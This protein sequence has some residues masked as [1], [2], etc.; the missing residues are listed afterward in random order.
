MGTCLSK[1]TPSSPLKQPTPPPQPQP[2]PNHVVVHPVKSC[3]NDTVDKVEDKEQKQK[4]MMLEEADP[5]VEAPRKVEEGEERVVKKKEVFVIKHRKSHDRER[6]A[7]VEESG[8]HDKMDDMGKARTT[9]DEVEDEVDAILI[10]CGRLSRSNSSGAGKTISSSGRKYSGSK[11]SFDFDQEGGDLAAAGD[12]DDVT[13]EKRQHRQRNRQPQSPQGRRRTRTPSRER[14]QNQRSGSRER[15]NGRRVSRSPGRRSEGATTTAT[16]IMTSNNASDSHNVASGSVKRPA[17]MVSVPPTVSSLA[18]DK[19]NE[20]QAAAAV[21]SSNTIKRIS[22]KR[23]VEAAG[24]RSSASPRSQSP[25][26]PIANGS[27]NQQPSLSRSSSRKA[28]HSPYRRNPLTDIDTNVLPPPTANKPT[29]TNNTLTKA[30]DV[31]TQKASYETAN[32]A[33]T[34]STNVAKEQP[35]EEFNAVLTTTVVPESLNPHSSSRS[36]SARQSRDLDFN[37][38]AL[39]NPPPSSY[40][41]LLLQDIHNF[42][43]KNNTNTPSFSLPP[44]VSKA[45]SILEAVAD[46]N[47]STSSN[48][49]DPKPSDDKRSH[50][51]AVANLVGKKVS[52]VKEPFVE[53]EILSSDDIMEPSFHKYVTVR[54]GGTTL[55]GGE[56]MDGQ[57]SSG[58]NSFVGCSQ[59]QWGISASSWEPNS[60]DSTDRWTSRSNHKEDDEKSSMGFQRHTTPEPGRNMEEAR[61]GFSGQ[62]TGIG[63][64]RV[65]TARN[66]QASPVVFAASAST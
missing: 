58:S 41:A 36:R 48:L 65:G 40:T 50:V 29:G 26:R 49:S 17:K 56:D 14:E 35:T 11:R 51:A 24:H 10:Q 47:S 21:S 52:E 6:S 64:G 63:R 9:E 1:K 4:K 33:I 31:Q 54:R 18:M 60:A 12:D 55:C 61:R 38:E 5:G 20:S 16:P 28:E 19:S 15:G 13:V 25:A 34:N 59:Q 44:C 2:Q 3:K 43:Q 23:S 66:V 32:R 7:E 30:K 27:N 8:G 46:L 62:R 22:V 37:P 53:S 45:C 39:L 42:H 57:E